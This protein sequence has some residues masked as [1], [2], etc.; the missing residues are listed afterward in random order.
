MF[1][2]TIYLLLIIGLIVGERI[3]IGINP[4]CSIS[5]SISSIVHD[6]DTR[7]FVVDLHRFRRCENPTFRVRLSGTALYILNL[8]K[9][10]YESLRPRDTDSIFSP[11]KN[12]FHYTYPPIQDPGEYFLEIIVIFCAE[13]QPNDFENVCVEDHYQGK[14]VVNAPYSVHL[15]TNPNGLLSN[16]PT[17]RWVLENNKGMSYTPQLLSTRYQ[18]RHC[19][20]NEVC[21][22]NHVE[23]NTLLHQQYEWRDQPD[24]VPAY[25]QLAK[26]TTNVCFI[27]ASHA[28]E[29][30]AHADQLV[31]L[32]TGLGLRFYY[33]ESRFPNEYNNTLLTAHPCDYAVIG[34]GQWPASFM[35]WP[36][37]W[38][39]EVYAAQMQ[40]VLTQVTSF[41]STSTI[42][43]FIRSVN[44]NGMGVVH[45][46]C[47]P[48]DHR[49]PPVIDMMNRILVRLC[50]DTGVSYID[51]SHIM[52]PMWDSAEDYC[53][54]R[55]R[56]F[57]AE[58]EWILH[59][60]F[61]AP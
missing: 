59:R 14:S 60:I 34:Y 17:P 42:K 37:A 52:G 33:L 47:P 29:L 23:V 24:W 11:R 21:A 3:N 40:R 9:H 2:I 30:F 49:S 31:G 5:S 58:V 41:A 22:E 35:A 54:P 50:S 55:G 38:T 53:H 13:F 48:I 8:T 19:S 10:H 45:T 36:K 15:P 56:V 61:T 4:H 57:T 25:K 18:P 46:H 27:G 6:T 1:L 16:P 43:V 32:T 28:R 20:D 51:T 7:E 44:Y 26:A 39:A 12:V